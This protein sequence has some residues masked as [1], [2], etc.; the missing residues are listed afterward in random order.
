MTFTDAINLAGEL[1]ESELAEF[2]HNPKEYCNAMN[3]PEDSIAT[4]KAVKNVD[5]IVTTADDSL[6]L[7]RIIFESKLEGSI[8]VKEDNKVS[9]FLV[10]CIAKHIVKSKK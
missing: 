4:K 5:S 6:A 3:W 2:K 7:G 1:L 9:D 10:N 8:E